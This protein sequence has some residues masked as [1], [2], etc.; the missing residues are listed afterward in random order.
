MPSWH[1][2][3]TCV[4]AFCFAWPDW[5][6]VITVNGGELLGFRQFIGRAVTVRGRTVRIVSHVL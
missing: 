6:A 2:A 5:T 3:A 4:S 1:E